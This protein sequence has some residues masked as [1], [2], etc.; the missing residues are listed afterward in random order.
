MHD[1]QNGKVNSMNGERRLLVY[2]SEGNLYIQPSWDAPNEGIDG[3]LIERTLNNAYLGAQPRWTQTARN[4]PP[5]C[6]IVL[7][8][9]DDPTKVQEAVCA[10]L[11][12]G[13]LG[14]IAVISQ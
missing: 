2:V 9:H 7:A 14:G 12:S 13:A 3:F 6:Y 10:E 4:Q 8:A 5:A 11:P 1:T